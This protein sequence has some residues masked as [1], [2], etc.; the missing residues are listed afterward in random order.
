[1]ERDADRNFGAPG[2]GPIPG[3]IVIHQMTETV[4]LLPTV[5][6]LC[7]IRETSPHNGNSLMPLIN[8]V[9][10]YQHKLYAFTEG[11]LLLEED[12]LL[13]EGNFPYDIKGNL[14]QTQTHMLEKAT[15]V[16]SRD[17]TYIYRLYEPAEIYDHKGDPGERHN[18]AGR[19]EWALVLSQLPEVMF[20]WLVENADVMSWEQDF[21]FGL[22]S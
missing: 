21:F 5:F 17:W 16:R 10:G 12:W 14:Q 6:E 9:P 13:E 20:R 11:G 7:N 8:Q 1:M 3:G 18:L 4:D 19:P 2:E 22:G 15:A